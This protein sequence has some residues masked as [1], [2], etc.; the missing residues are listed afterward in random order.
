MPIIEEIEKRRAD[1]KASHD[2]ARQDQEVVD[3]DAIDAL[4]AISGEPF[5]TMSANGF[6]AG[7]P[8]KVAFRSPSAIE[9]KRYCDMVGKAQAKNDPLARRQ[10]QELLALVCL[11][12]PPSDSDSRKALLD[13]FPGVL[14]SVA[15]ECAKAAE[16]RNEDEGKG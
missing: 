8:V 13:S 2:K 6:K 16:L 7:V 5:M 10:G 3:L 1:R 11:V 12:Y 14:L 4:E 9:Y 15:I